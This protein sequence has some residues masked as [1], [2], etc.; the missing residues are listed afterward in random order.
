M[1]GD[2][3]GILWV[4][5][6]HTSGFEPSAPDSWTTDRGRF[7]GRR[8]RCKFQHFEDALGVIEACNPDRFSYLVRKPL[9]QRSNSP[10]GPSCG[11]LPIVNFRSTSPSYRLS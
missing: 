11:R 9:R 8:V 1:E 5:D 7:V 6:V 2:R 3:D 10:Y 4:D